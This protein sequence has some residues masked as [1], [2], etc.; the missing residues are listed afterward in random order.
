M[1]E[2]EV[3]IELSERVLEQLQAT[4]MDDADLRAAVRGALA[5]EMLRAGRLSM[6]LAADV[7][8]LDR[9]EFVASLTAHGVPAINLSDE[10][11]A[12]EFDLL[13]SMLGKGGAQ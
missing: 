6:G 9:A 3:L 4:G 12:R 11:L 1:L 2:P 8:G 7:A 10:D 13:D 5:R